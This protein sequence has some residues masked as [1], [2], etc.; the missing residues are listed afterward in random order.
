MN[1]PVAVQPTTPTLFARRIAAGVR[2]GKLFAPGDR[3]LVALSGGPDSV[4]LLSLLVEL[5]PS[6]DLRLAA[7]H[8]NYGLRGEE[9]DE[10][11]RFAA[12]LCDR[13]SVPFQCERVS[14]AREGAQGRQRSSLQ[15]IAREARYEVLVRAGRKLG[16][17]K[18]ALG[19]QADDQAETLLMWML[20][21]AGTAGLAGIPPIRES[22]FIRP[23]LQVSRS[24]ILDYLK[25]RRV[26]FRSDSS[27]DKPLYLRNRVRHELLPMLKRYNPAIVAT[28]LRQADILR[29]DDLCLEQ[30]G[31]EQTARVACRERDGVV[32][33]RAGLLALPVALQRRVIRSVLRQL[34]GNENG[35]TFGAVATILDRLIQSRSGSVVTV[36]G[37]RVERTYAR[38]RFQSVGQSDPSPRTKARAQAASKGLVLAV[39]SVLRWPL[40]G[41][42]LRAGL[43][44]SST[45]SVASAPTPSRRVAVF[46]AD[47]V[48]GALVVRSWKP[49]DRFSPSGMQGRTKKLQDY[50]ADIKLPRLDRAKVPL[51]ATPEGILWV[52]GYR[53]D[54]RFLATSRTTRTLTVE[55]LDEA[56]EGGA[57]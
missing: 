33:D 1:R 6:W 29:E 45:G 20:R 57:G 56:S 35:P 47:R 52:C 39:P 41:Q 8:V 23:L 44:T 36:E 32:V 26:S 37:V 11:A 42:S 2:A 9:S 22:F 34:N 51:L 10:D 12:A 13:F 3:L 55:L 7:L 4:A 25:E 24:E 15:E 18:I 50:F 27:N 17:D 49:G 40:T 46:D 54:H 38:L 31:R 21:G 30:W 53:A 28:L 14:L 43:A 19:H 48:T 16:V 5:A